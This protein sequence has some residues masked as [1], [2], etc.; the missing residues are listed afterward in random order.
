MTSRVGNTSRG[1]SLLELI[2]VLVVLGLS[3]LIVLPNIDKGMRDRDVRRSALALAATAREL[4]SQAL[5]KGVPQQLLL[6][7]SENVYFAA[8]SEE[9]HLPSTVKFAAIEGGESLESGS[10]QFWFFP[11]GSAL[12][13][14]IDL[15]S[16]D[17]FT[18]Y[19]VRLH[20]LTGK[21][22]VLRIGKS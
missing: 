13:G 4:R 19:S 5:L 6:R 16:A 20:P 1:F 12:S 14:Q 15:S 10:H 2:L 18:Q 9:V 8:R 21:V 11:N 3:T 22:E 17:D 7:T